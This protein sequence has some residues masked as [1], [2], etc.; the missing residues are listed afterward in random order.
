M[1]TINHIINPVNV[2]P[3]SDLYVAQPV[4]FE[5]MRRAREF[6][7]TD[8]E[9]RLLTTQ[10][11]EDRMI[12]PDYFIKTSDL[13]RSIIDISEF[14]VKRKLPLIRDILEKAVHYNP[15]ADYV[16]CTNVDIALMPHFY[17]FV[18]Q[19]I[20]EGFDSFVINRRTI[21]KDHNINTLGTAYSEYG[22]DHPGYDCFIFKREMFNDMELGNICIGA[23]YIGLALFLNLNLL[24]N[25]FVEFGDEH[26]T[27]HIGNDKVW[28]NPENSMY[29]AHNKNEFE[30]V[31]K[32]LGSKYSN[33]ESVLSA[34]FPNF[35]GT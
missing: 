9:V 16:I 4:T 18:S 17:L 32:L 26:L 25:K 3:S 23:A 30:K 35:N 6:S 11:T 33:V 31:K 10:Y 24:S 34:A 7:N 5:S 29:E 1:L 13:D 21:S 22:C 2:S 14:Q 12:I 15:Q 8:L 28:K 20:K 27:F 19:K